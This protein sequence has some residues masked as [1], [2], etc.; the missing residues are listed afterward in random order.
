MFQVKE[1]Y[2]INHPEIVV[3]GVAADKLLPAEAKVIAPYNGDTAFLYQIKRF[4]WP[5]VD[6]SFEKMISR[7]ADYFVAVNFADP[8]VAYVEKNFK[9]LEKTGQYLIVDLSQGAE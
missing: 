8:D 2:K 3:A 7:G 5:V 6:E 9:V 1:F 4:G